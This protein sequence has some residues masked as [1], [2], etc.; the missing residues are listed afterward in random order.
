MNQTAS[1]PAALA[2]AFESLAKYDR[3]SSRGSLMPIDD[4]VVASIGDDAVRGELEQRLIAVLRSTASAVAK[5]YACSKLRLIGSAGA[6]PALAAMLGGQN[7]AHAA[8][9]ALQAM[10]CVEA[11]RAIR[12]SLPRLSGLE[13]VG[14][15]NSLGVRRDSA[16]VGQ[17]AALLD[18]PDQ[19]IAAAAAAA[20]GEV[21]TVEASQA[22]GRIESASTELADALLVCAEHLANAGS[23]D[24]AAAIYNALDNPRQ[25]K[26][27]R[28]AANRGA[29]H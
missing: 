17:L 9:D 25:S 10:P 24:A 12:D 7:L 5:Q 14:A 29:R 28:W 8:R 27:V 16:S 6:V 1:T 3:G 2:E 11:V 15:I 19:R 18:D 20:L 21:G 23:K 22:L 4:A 13:K 26:H